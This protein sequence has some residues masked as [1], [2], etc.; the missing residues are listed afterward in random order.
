MG[1]LRCSPATNTTTH[2]LARTHSGPD[3]HH[4]YPSQG[5]SKG[6]NAKAAEEQQQQALQDTSH[7]AHN[8]PAVS[9][10]TVAYCCFYTCTGTVTGAAARNSR[11]L[12]TLKSNL[13]FRQT[14][15]FAV[16][17]CAV[18]DDVPQVCIADCEG[19]MIEPPQMPL[20]EDSFRAR[21]HACHMLY[22]PTL[23]RLGAYDMY[24]CHLL[25]AKVSNYCQAWLKAAA[26]QW[27]RLYSSDGINT[28]APA[29]THE[30]SLG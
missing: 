3:H 7:P 8:S 15:V 5:P 6:G 23:Q 18:D 12:A 17:T 19:P 28:G 16:C 20:C 24:T 13:F 1:Q 30:L 11:E 10:W 29:A 25:E 26:V 22:T 9:A 4:Q 2:T 21:H 14:I 27:Q